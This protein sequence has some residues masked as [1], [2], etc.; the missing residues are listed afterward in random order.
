M[1]SC[2]S[3]DLMRTRT[4]PEGIFLQEVSS[5]EAAMMLFHVPGAAAFSEPL[6]LCHAAQ[7]AYLG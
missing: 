7:L 4:L 1:L 5:R 3:D 6:V 2:S